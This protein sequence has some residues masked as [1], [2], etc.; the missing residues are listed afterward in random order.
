MELLA[1]AG[2]TDAS[3]LAGYEA[4]METCSKPPWRCLCHFTVGKTIINH[5]PKS[6]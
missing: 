1:D 5:P 6:P 2:E 3:D 4:G